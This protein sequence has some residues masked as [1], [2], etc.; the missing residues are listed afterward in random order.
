MAESAEPTHG[1]PLESSMPG[2]AVPLATIL[3]REALRRDRH[4]RPIDLHSRGCSNRRCERAGFHIDELRSLQA[5]LAA[6][7]TRMEQPSATK[8]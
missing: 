5:R 2:G 1:V 4:H 6:A 3:L 7:A 8:H